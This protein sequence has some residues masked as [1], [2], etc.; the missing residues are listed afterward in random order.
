MLD[1]TP[2]LG[3]GVGV[4]VAGVGGA[5]AGAQGGGGPRTASIRARPAS[6]RIT[7][8]ELE[9]LFQRQADADADAD[10]NGVGCAMMTRSAFQS[11]STSPPCSPYSPA[12]PTRVYA[13]VAEMKRS[14]TKLWSKTGSLRRDFH[15]TPDLAAEL[16]TRPTRTRSSDDVHAAGRAPPPAEAPPPPPGAP[17]SSFR[18]SAAAKLYA[19]PQELARVA[20][21]PANTDAQARGVAG[22]RAWAGS[23]PPVGR[24]LSADDAGHQYAQPFNP[25]KPFVRQSSTPAPPIPEPDYSMSESDDEPDK[26]AEPVAETS[27]NSN[28]RPAICVTIYETEGEMYC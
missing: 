11:G 10:T 24:A 2:V 20:Y 21:R 4:G 12:R 23:A 5:G 25:H 22:P 7:A 1:G 9:E 6:G 28:A 16:A 13:S 15:S 17:A 27:A 18:P 19:S 3:V 8:A 14:R 26:P